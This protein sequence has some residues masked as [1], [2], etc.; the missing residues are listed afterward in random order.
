M[1]TKSSLYTLK[2]ENV[3]G[4]LI[5]EIGGEWVVCKEKKHSISSTKSLSKKI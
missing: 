2:R 5:V 1:L 3:C 4:A